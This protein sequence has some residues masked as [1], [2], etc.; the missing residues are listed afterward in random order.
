MGVGPETVMIGDEDEGIGGTLADRLD[1]TQQMR[2]LVLCARTGQ[3]DGLILEDVPVLRHNA[4]LDHLEQGVVL[5]ASD[6]I[7]AGIRP[8]GEQPIVVV[9][10]VI[11]DN[12][13]GREVHLMGGLDVGHLAV[14]DDAEAR[15]IAITIEYQMR[16]DRALGATE[17]RPV[18]HGKAQID[19]GRIDADQFVLEAK[20]LLLAHRLGD[21]CR[22][23][24]VE[25]LFEQFPR[26]MPAGVG[27]RR[28]C[29]CLDAQV[30]EFALA[31]L[32]P[33]FDLP[34]GVGA[35]QLVEQHA[36]ELAPARQP[37]AAVLRSCLFDHALEVGVRNE[38]EYF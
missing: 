21:D 32:Q 35:A 11:D 16:L 33:A 36:D 12:G 26:P 24:T 13:V 3:T 31:A 6:K 9:A 29:R 15:Q 30:G 2:T 34:Q 1:P 10:P 19:D 7:D 27:Q 22:E 8:L 18:I 14:G 38:L 4:F 25:D 28:A 23:Q 20:L 5:H 37:L 17:L